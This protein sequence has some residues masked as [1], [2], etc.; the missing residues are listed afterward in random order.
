MSKDMSNGKSIWDE[1][2]DVYLPILFGFFLLVAGGACL[3]AGPFFPVGLSGIVVWVAGGFGIYLF[4]RE[5]KAK[6]VAEQ[7]AVY[8]E[9]KAEA[10]KRALKS[11]LAKVKEDLAVAKLQTKAEAAEAVAEKPVVKKKAKKG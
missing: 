2:V 10:E 8:T 11:E 5:R 4:V 7:M 9:D 6:H 1:C 3:N